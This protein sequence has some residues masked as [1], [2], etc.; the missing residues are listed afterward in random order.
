M[1]AIGA[2]YAAD[3]DMNCGSLRWHM[4]AKS[5]HE[6]FLS[7]EANDGGGSLNN[8]EIPSASTSVKALRP[9]RGAQRMRGLDRRFR[10]G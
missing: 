5:L 9:L 1:I 2:L 3:C 8:G 6:A 4:A 7:K 10:S